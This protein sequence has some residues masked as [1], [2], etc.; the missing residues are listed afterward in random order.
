MAWVVPFYMIF[1]HANYLS[2]YRYFRKRHG[3]GILKAFWYSYLNHFRFGQI[4]ID[5]FAM[6]AG[7]KFEVETEGQEIFDALDARD[8]GFMIISSHIG[9][10]ELAGYTLTPKNK[11]FNVLVFSQETEQVMKGREHMFAGRHIHMIPLKEDMSHVFRLNEALLEGNI[12]S[13]PG[14]RVFGSSR[15]LNVQFLGGEAPLPL[16]PF[17]MVAQRNVEAISVF[18]VKEGVH[19]YHAFVKPLSIPKG[20]SGKA[21]PGEL[22]KS[23]IQNVEHVLQEYPEQWFN[24]YNFW[25]E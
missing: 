20:T 23:F 16:G 7:K 22:A 2:I 10:Y 13:I 5:R 12:V 24:Y 17:A 25:K 6:Y 8:A 11:S 9:N 4:I 19:K 14:D 18:V 3:C 15:T 1:N 21:K